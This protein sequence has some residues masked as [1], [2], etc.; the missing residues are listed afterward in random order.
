MVFRPKSP[1]NAGNTNPLANRPLP[2]LPE[3]ATPRIPPA[4]SVAA[5]MPLQCPTDEELEEA[6]R[7]LT[8]MEKKEAEGGWFGSRPLEVQ[9]GVAVTEE[10]VEGHFA[11]LKIAD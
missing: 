3:E 7:P 11:D 1:N 6:R 10:G 4:L 9:D 2:P 8:P 5:N